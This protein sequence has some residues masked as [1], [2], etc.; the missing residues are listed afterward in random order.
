MPADGGA[1]EPVFQLS[2]ASAGMNYLGWSNMYPALRCPSSPAARCIIAEEEKNALVFSA[3]DP[4]EGR[5]IRLGQIEA[6][7]REIAWD[8]SPDG[9]RVAYVRWAWDDGHKISMM[10]L[11][12]GRVTEIPMKG[13]TSLSAVAWAPD[14]ANLYVISARR[15]GSALLRVGIDGQVTTLRTDT[16]SWL[17]NPRPSPDGRRLAFAATTADSKVWL[18]ERN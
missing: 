3:F 17:L 6:P 8:L 15:N 14:A 2:G 1:S 11:Q 18:V 7:P 12:D 4:M 9:T 13:W 16:G 10:G 5:R